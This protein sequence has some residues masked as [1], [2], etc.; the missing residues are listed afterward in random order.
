M[1]GLLRGIARTA[2]VAGTASG[3]AGRVQRRQAS[4]FAE[5]DA[6]TAADRQQ[7]YDQDRAAQAPQ[8]APQPQYAPPPPAPQPDLVSQLKQLAELKEQG[9]LTEDEFNAQKAKLLSR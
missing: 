2:V 9:I 6:Q 3:V 8:Y 5:R 7:A 4:K 1:P